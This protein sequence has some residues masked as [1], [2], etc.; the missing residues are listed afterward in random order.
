[1][2]EKLKIEVDTIPVFRVYVGN[3]ESL[4]C[5]QICRRIPL[6]LQ[7][8]NF[9]ID[10]Y[11]LPIHGPDVVLGIQ[12]LSM[13]GRVTH[14]YAALTM[15]FSWE[16]RRIKLKGDNSIRR[17]ITLHSL[18]ALCTKGQLEEAF[19]LFFL[20]TPEETELQVVEPEDT[21]PLVA[22]LIHNYAAI[23][24]EPVSLPPRRFHDHRVYLNPGT[25]PVNVR[26]YRYPHIQKTQ[27]E[28]M[29]RE[30]MEQGI[31]RPSR[32]PFSSSVLLVKKKD[33]S[34]RFCVDYRALNTVTVPD[35]FPIPTADELFDELGSARV[36][37]KLDLRSGYYQI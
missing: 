16:G 23:F 6:E 26:P 5:S 19:E 30:M 15:D 7:K 12:W 10:M 17:G 13:L 11:V 27:I 14:D 25:K 31:I 3:G 20:D 21:P 18:Q 2:V 33:G 22:Q 37:S 36:F 8:H 35:H 28:K 9:S 4:Q 1:M 24:K 32:S 34:F 29:V